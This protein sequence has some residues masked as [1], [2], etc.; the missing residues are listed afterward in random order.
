[1]ALAFALQSYVTQT[2]IH[3]TP[4]ELTNLSAAA[5]PGAKI[6][7]IGVRP[8][9]GKFAPQDKY[10]ANDDPANCPICQEILHAGQFVAPSAIVFALPTEAVAVVPL[11]LALFTP[12][13]AAS[14]NW[15]GRAPPHA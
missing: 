6:A 12:R 10:P 3:F 14:H 7:A 8:A 9:P 11:S 5:Q 15:Q 1:M 4:A 2:H 13:E